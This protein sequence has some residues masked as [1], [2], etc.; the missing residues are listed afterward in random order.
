MDKLKLIYTLE[1]LKCRFFLIA[2]NAIGVENIF[3][4]FVHLVLSVLI[5]L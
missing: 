4:T 5:N 1:D 2:A 3:Y